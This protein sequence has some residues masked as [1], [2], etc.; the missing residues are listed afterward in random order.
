[1]QEIHLNN[2][3]VFRVARGLIFSEKKRLHACSDAFGEELRLTPDSRLGDEPLA[4]SA[5]EIAQTAGTIAGFFTLDQ[6]MVPRLERQETIAGWVDLI[7]EAWCARQEFITFFTSGSTGVPKPVRRRFSQLARDAVFL[8]SLHGRIDRVVTQVPP[9]YIYGF[10]YNI[11]IPRLLGVPCSD[12]RF[13]SPA[14]VVA[15]LTPGDLVIGTPFSWRLLAGFTP[16]LPA[17]IEGVSSTAPCPAE[18]ATALLDKG[19]EKLAEIY[20]STECGAMGYRITP[21]APMTLSPLWERIDGET[22]IRR[23]P[24]GSPSEPFRFQDELAWL[25]ETRFRVLKRI[26]GATQ[27]GGFNVHLGRVAEVIRSCDMVAD[28]A[29]RLMRPDEGDRLKAF[30]VLEQGLT[31]D[32]EVTRALR[33]HMKR[34]LNHFEQPRELRFGAALPR[35]EMGKAADW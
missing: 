5:E 9:H 6:S 21:D 1:M 25:D 20:G 29:V 35:N 18:L 26:D 14:G 8:A 30:I 10:I 24:D 16:E 32:E 2:D 11:L 12:Q 19:L 28:C 23:F 7:V 33:E 13:G 34:R 27:V 31:P 3:D 4:L 15:E 17:G 22:F